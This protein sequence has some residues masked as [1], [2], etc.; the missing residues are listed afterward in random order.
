MFSYRKRTI[1]SLSQTRL[2]WCKCWL[3]WG[4]ADFVAQILSNYPVYE[5]PQWVCNELIKINWL[6][7]KLFWA[8]FQWSF[9]VLNIITNLQNTVVSGIFNNFH[10]VTF[11]TVH[12]L[13]R[14]LLSVTGTLWSGS[15]LFKTINTLHFT[16]D[17]SI[18]RINNTHA[19]SLI[20]T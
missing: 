2:I 15:T 5:L 14:E 12:T 16:Q 11:Q 19:I 3:I 10:R 8:R 7:V 17:N 13:I 6:N 1:G 4:R 18:E 9:V 20:I